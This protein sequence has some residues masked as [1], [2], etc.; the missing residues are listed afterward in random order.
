MIDNI[1]IVHVHDEALVVTS[2]LRRQN[3]NKKSHYSYRDEATVIVG[4]L[5]YKIR[6]TKQ[7]T[8]TWEHGQFWFSYL[9]WW[10]V[11]SR[12]SF[13]F[14]LLLRRHLVLHFGHIPHSF[15]LE[16]HLPLRPLLGWHRG[17][18]FVIQVGIS[19]SGV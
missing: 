17:R 12:Y 7:I 10:F 1:E 13:P 16:C 9:W 6:I 5:E 8:T 2:S 18:C 3:S 14:S 19:S 4:G 11:P 15:P